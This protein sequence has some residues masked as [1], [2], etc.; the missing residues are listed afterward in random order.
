MFIQ[1]RVSEFWTTPEELRYIA[2]R[3]E[4]RFERT[5]LGEE[6]PKYTIESSNWTLI[7]VLDHTK[8]NLPTKAV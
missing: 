7:F 4:K 5:K 6:T 1:K 8:M 2:N 3:L